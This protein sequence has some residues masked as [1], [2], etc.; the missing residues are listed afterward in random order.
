[1]T[2]TSRRQVT[3]EDVSNSH[4]ARNSKVTSREPASAMSPATKETP[5]VLGTPAT[6]GNHATANA[7]VLTATAMCPGIDDTRLGLRLS[8]L[9]TA[10]LLNRWIL[11]LF[12]F[13][14]Y[15]I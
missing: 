3:A 4:Y 12:T 5:A 11:N 6:A 14:F 10:I 7:A 1:M 9:L 2:A 15:F 8:S 13:N